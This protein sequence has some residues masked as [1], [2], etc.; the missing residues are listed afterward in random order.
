[1]FYE[2]MAKG[3]I[4]FKIQLSVSYPNFPMGRDCSYKVNLL[5]YFVCW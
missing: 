2:S 4:N 1:M 3:V 5:V